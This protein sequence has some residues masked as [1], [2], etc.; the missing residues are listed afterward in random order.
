MTH[1]NCSYVDWRYD[2]VL[3]NRL[4]AIPALRLIN[5]ILIHTQYTPIHK[6]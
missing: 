6:L 2:V 5:Y 4:Q 1:F 3:L